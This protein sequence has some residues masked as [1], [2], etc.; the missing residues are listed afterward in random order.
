MF[1]CEFWKIFRNIS[2]Q[3]TS[4]K[5]LISC[6]MCRISQLQ[7]KTISRVPFK[8][9]IQEPEEALQRRSDNMQQENT[10]AEVW[11]Q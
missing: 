1:F 6:K 4:R 11:F 8:Y 5:L 3:S 7:Q 9:F 2:R 10:H